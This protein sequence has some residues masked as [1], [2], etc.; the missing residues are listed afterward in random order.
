MLSGVLEM[1]EGEVSATALFAHCFT[2]GKDFLPERR[3]TRGLAR[4]GIATLRIDFSGLGSSEGTFSDTSF[5][6]NLDDLISV[7]TWL[8]EH[9]AAPNLLVGHSLGGAAVL[10]AAGR[11]PS[12]KAVATIAA[13]ADPQH[14]THLF[15]NHLSEIQAKGEAEVT[16]AGRSFKIGKKFLEDLKGHNHKESLKGLKG[17]STL[18]MHA[19]DDEVVSV[20][21]AGEI[22]SALPHPKSFMALSGADHLLTRVKDAEYVAELIKT[23]SNYV[24]ST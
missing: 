2:C 24:L 3:I 18:I 8:K 4:R 5:L 7:A 11:I 17:V 22:Y 1:P 19:P 23:W 15:Q 16:L 9:L 20:K 12:V 10:A 14:V 13:P 21:N 6:T